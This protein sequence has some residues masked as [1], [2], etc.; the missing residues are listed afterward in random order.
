MVVFFG[1]LV[2]AMQYFAQF[3]I[4][5]ARRNNHAFA[6]TAEEQA[7]LI[8]NYNPLAVGPQ[9]QAYFF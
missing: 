4:N 1:W 6:N 3:F 5:E 8:F 2:R 9:K 7:S